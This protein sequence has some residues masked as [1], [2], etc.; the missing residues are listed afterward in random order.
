V[1]VKTVQS[2]IAVVLDRVERLR[3]LSDKINNDFDVFIAEVR[4]NY[5]NKV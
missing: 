2:K 4:D 3:G 5:L 1:T